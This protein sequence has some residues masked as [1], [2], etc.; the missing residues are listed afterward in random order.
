MTKKIIGIGHAIIDVICK[1]EDD[2]LIE[3]NLVKSSMTL[4]DYNQFQKLSKL[5]I[6]KITSGGSVGNTIATLGMLGV[7]SYF[8]GSVG[9]DEFGKKFIEQLQQANCKFI[10]EII[11][12]Q[13]SGISFILV[14]PDGERTM[15]TFIGCASMINQKLLTNQIFDN[16]QYLYIEGYLWDGNHTSNSIKKA[17]E[18]AKE[19]NTK[20]AFSLSDSFCVSRHR[21]D[22]LELITNDI[23]LLFANENEVIDLANHQQYSFEQTNN[24]F[25]N[26][27]KKQQDFTAVIT[28]SEKGCNVIKLI[29]QNKINLNLE[30]NAKEV[31]KIVDTTGAGDNF[32]SGWFFGEFKNPIYKSL[33]Q[34]IIKNYLDQSANFANLLASNIIQKYGARFEAEEL[35]KILYN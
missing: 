23:S 19:S 2:F 9:D 15:C 3:N 35:N 32:A 30:V 18:I 25:K 24:F 16:C 33:D 8:I 10:G 14:S 22:F 5:K 20:I 29:D 26:L 13:N 6:E 7:E 31:K 27:P 28:R 21:D 12:N 17:I 4:I 11:S 1:V 34:N